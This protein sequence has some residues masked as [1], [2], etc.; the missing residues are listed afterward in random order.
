MIRK[1]PAA[2]RDQFTICTKECG[3]RCCRYITIPIATPVAHD[4]WDQLRWWL[5]HEGI[6]ASKDEDGWQLVVETRCKNLRADNA[7]GIYPHHMDTCKEYDPQYCEYPG[8]IE[9]DLELFT[10]SDLAAYLERRSLKRGKAVAAA[11]RQAE[12]TRTTGM[13]APLVSLQG[14]TPQAH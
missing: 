8:P 4:D 14:L 1:T 2:E 3:A 13:R 6:S 11:I 7:C 5:A 10:E 12:K 9:V